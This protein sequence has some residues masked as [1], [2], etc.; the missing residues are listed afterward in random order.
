MYRYNDYTRIQKKFTRWLSH[1]QLTWRWKFLITGT[2]V[3][4]EGKV[5]VLNGGKQI[6]END[7]IIFMKMSDISPLFCATL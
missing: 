4:I 1:S 3:V 6:V 2:E 5:G 7:T